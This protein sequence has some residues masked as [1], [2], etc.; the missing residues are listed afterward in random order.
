VLA[1]DVLGR[2]ALDALGAGVPID[3]NAVGIEHEQRVVD[4]AGDERAE[5]VRGF[6]QLLLR[7]LPLG[8]VAGDLGK[9]DQPIIL[10]A[11]GVDLDQRPEAAAVFAHAPAFAFE[12]ALARGR[13]QHPR[14]HADGAVFR[15]VETRE[16]LADDFV[17]GIAFEPL[18]A[19]I[20]THDHAARVE[21]V[22]GVILDRLD[23]QAKP[24]L[25]VVERFLRLAPFGDIPGDN[26]KAHGAAVSGAHRLR[27]RGGP[28]SRSILAGTPSLMLGA[29]G[30]PRPRQELPGNIR[31]P[32]LDPEEKG[33][34][35]TDDFAGAVEVDLFGAPVPGADHAFGVDQIDGIVGEGV[36]QELEPLGIRELLDGTGEAQFHYWSLCYSPDVYI[37]RKYITCRV[38]PGNDEIGYT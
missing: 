12:M 27:Q 1:D 3:H 31:S 17:G 9:A 11:D 7:H 36:N 19:R 4:H 10:V 35:L 38:K 8:D 20:P 22:D 16:M 5:L 15:R 25:A 29:A 18:S 28:K 30:K 14:R 32:I 13:L 6:A 2:I 23:Q 21:H 26:R 34:V 37:T 33:K 24:A